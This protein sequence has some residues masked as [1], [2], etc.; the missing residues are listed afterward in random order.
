MRVFRPIRKTIHF[1]V[2]TRIQPFS[3]QSLHEEALKIK[4]FTTA[5]RKLNGNR[6]ASK[7]TQDKLNQDKMADMIAAGAHGI[8]NLLHCTNTNFLP[9]FRRILRT[10]TIKKP[11]FQRKPEDSHRCKRKKA[12]RPTIMGE[13]PI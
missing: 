13:N 9:K 3:F 11:D 6:Y 10:G 7:P 5:T 12:S 1:N 2:Q 4:I 8:S